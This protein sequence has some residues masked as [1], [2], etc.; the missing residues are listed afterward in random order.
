M[1][2]LFRWPHSWSHLFRWRSTESRK[3]TDEKNRKNWNQFFPNVREWWFVLVVSSSVGSH[4]NFNRAKD[5]AAQRNISYRTFDRVKML[6]F[7]IRFFSYLVQFF[8]CYFHS[9]I[10]CYFDPHI[11]YNKQSQPHNETLLSGE[12]GEK[13]NTKWE[14]TITWLSLKLITF[15][16]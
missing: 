6:R 11:V 7:I 1:G 9:C 5:S 12:G 16:T 10:Y 4:R 14:K 8:R 13:T 2:Q 15:W 3:I